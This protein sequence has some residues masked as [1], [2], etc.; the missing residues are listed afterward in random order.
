[1]DALVLVL[2]NAAIYLGSPFIAVYYVVHAW[3]RGHSLSGMRERLGLVRRLP[4]AGEGGR[5]WLHAVSVGEVGVAAA[6]VP[7]LLKKRPGLRIVLSTVTETGR[8]EAGKIDGVEHVFY[9]PFDYP[10][11]VRS[12]FRRIGPGGIAIIE[13]ELWPNLMWE[14]ARC[15][16]PVCVINGR[17]SEKSLRGYTRLRFLFA[18]V[19]K[20]LAGVA[21]RGEA[22]AKRY[23]S[24]GAPGVFAAGNIKF[25][26][27]APRLGGSTEDLK[28]NFGLAGADPIIVAG[29]T[30]P[31]E[32]TGLTGAI[33]ALRERFERLGVLIAPRHLPR[34]EE[35][36]AELRRG[37]LD[38]V[39]WS[40]I[41]S[42]SGG[43]GGQVV[44][45]DRMG[46][47]AEAYA[48][49]TAA[50][51]GG[52]LIP[53][54]GQNPIEAARWG[55]PVVFGP[56]MDNFAEVAGDLL[57]VE[58]AVRVESAEGLAGALLPWL[59]DRA[60]RDAASTSAMEW[61][62]A[63]SGAAE[64]TSE[65]LLGVLDSRGGDAGEEKS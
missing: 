15:G 44:L 39:R 30:H 63:N 53:H 17:L 47:L 52:S 21:A 4:P 9:L 36:E 3:T 31:G 40:E 46:E 60:K 56:H 48:C 50:F 35:A 7:E 25:D 10:H 41:A 55:V 27:P 12:A 38:P 43:G 18:P 24:L 16:L 32:M 42:R 49:G 13:T 6:L 65:F 23:R 19:L 61:V 57:R 14:A 34:L 11:T 59:S 20:K 1:M 33:H 37:G 45:L 22:D 5:V 26:A 58:G 62:A 51:I 8:E 28:K 29:S 2:Y 64:R 54:G